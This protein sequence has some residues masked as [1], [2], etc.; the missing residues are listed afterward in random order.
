M[1]FGS[2]SLLS[3]EN[4]NFKEAVVMAE[5]D[6]IEASKSVTKRLGSLLELCIPMN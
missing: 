1:E 4:G 5:A 3:Y 2:L 6:D